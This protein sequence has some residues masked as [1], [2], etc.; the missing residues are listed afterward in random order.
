MKIKFLYSLI[1]I[2]CM[3]L[4]AFAKDNTEAGKGNELCKRQENQVTTPA[5][6]ITASG[7]I[8]DLSPIA[9][10]FSWEI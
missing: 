10:L 1:F 3:T 4:I 6:K 7:N 9:L 2:F 8:S 5:E